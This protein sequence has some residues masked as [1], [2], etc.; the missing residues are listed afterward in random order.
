MSTITT[1]AELTPGDRETH[2]PR[3]D[4]SVEGAGAMERVA[5]ETERPQ[6]A[7][8]VRD[9]PL[10]DGG[11]VLYQTCTQQLMTLNPTAALIWECCD[12]TLSIPRIVAEVREVFP[13]TPQVEDDVLRL[14]QELLANGMIVDDGI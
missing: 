3:A 6:K 12:G 11:M 5:G 8:C 14:L 7:G 13:D 4:L 9:E 10:A 2:N 1:H